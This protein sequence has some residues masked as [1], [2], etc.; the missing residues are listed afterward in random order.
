MKGAETRML[1]RMCGVTRLNRIRNE[2]IKDPEREYIAM[3]WT[4]VR[5][6]DNDEKIGG[7]IIVGKN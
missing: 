3:V 6:V 4:R 1:R 7:E 5:E 2:R